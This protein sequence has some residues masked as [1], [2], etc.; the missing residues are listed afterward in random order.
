MQA[1][2]I[3]TIIATASLVGLGL[4][5]AC[6]K[7]PAPSATTSDAMRA[8]DNGSSMADGAA[9]MSNNSMDADGNSMAA[10]NAM[11]DSMQASNSMQKNSH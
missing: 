6:S 11:S 8:T 7:E 10:D 4:L 2:R 3:R 9:M 5:S 1:I